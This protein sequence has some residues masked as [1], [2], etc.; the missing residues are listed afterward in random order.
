MNDDH[1]ERMIRLLEEL[2][3]GQRT[4]LERQALALQR[5]E[6]VLGQQR[7]RLAGLSKRNER[8]DNLLASGTNNVKRAR[9]LLSLAPWSWCFV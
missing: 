2:R 1:A 9:S 8:I 6:E 5:Q 4:M 3:D 7:E